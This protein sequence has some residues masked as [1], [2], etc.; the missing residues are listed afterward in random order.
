M[1]AEY[2]AMNNQVVEDLFAELL[3]LAPD[4]REQHL[5]VSESSESDKTAAARLVK[6]FES[7]SN[8]LNDD[9]LTDLSR[10]DPDFFSVYDDESILEIGDRVNSYLVEDVCGE[11]GMSIVYQACQ[12][13]PIKRK[14][15]LKLIRPSVLTPKTVLR[16]IRE[17]QALATVQ[18]P[19]I[20]TLY[21][22]G[23]T[24]KGH[25]FAAMEYVDG[26][27]I[28]QFCKNHQ[29][30]SRFRIELFIKA[31]QG[32]VHAHRSRI[33]HRD[34]KPENILV[35]MQRQG[36][37]AIPKLIDFGIA[38]FVS[39]PDSNQTM[40]RPGQV[41]GSPRYMSPEQIEGKDI[42]ERSDIYSAALVLFELLSRSP[43]RSGDTSELLLSQAQTP[44]IELLSERVARNRKLIEQQASG[45][46]F[47]SLQSMAKRDL[48]WILKK[49]LSR[50][51][52]DRYP[53]LEAF[54]DDL[55]ASFNGTPISLRKPGL[56]ERA[57]RFTKANRKPLAAIAA[58]VLILASSIVLYN[59]RQSEKEL[60]EI[61]LANKVNE[62][63]NAASNDLIIRLFASNQYKLSPEEIDSSSIRMYEDQY[64]QIR[65]VGGPQNQEEKS[66]YGILAVFYAMS[67]NFDK[68]DSLMEQVTDQQQRSELQRV[69][70]KICENYAQNA[71]Q[72]LARLSADDQSLEK[73]RQQLVLGRCYIV[74]NML[75]DSEQLIVDAIQ[76]FDTHADATCE[77]LIARNT[78]AKLYEQSGQ[79]GARKELLTQTYNEY[80]GNAVLQASLIGRNAYAKTSQM[81]AELE[82]NNNEGAER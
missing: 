77:S 38:K 63:R 9:L 60:S 23:T 22:V 32:L 7:R 56:F 13:D 62:E 3:E 41:L 35:A 52:D 69:R 20:A 16:F 49:A 37:I 53:T 61:K 26:I 50:A 73:A 29:T 55:K 79:L 72:T 81:F 34:I 18:H 12:T 21:E 33:I 76:I 67:G 46:E 57:S 27:P 5:A 48:N 65:S 43:Y 30:N 80:Q 6:A 44:D 4:Q 15:A 36:N 47:S 70:E 42:D 59:W 1:A 51:P 39:D 45:K 19:N 54:L 14:V 68:A 25:P 40:T 71:K 78:L 17:Q 75:E 8:F 2:Y 24:P 74:L 58:A 64:E 10:I 11:G 66:V 31:C 28:T 82:T